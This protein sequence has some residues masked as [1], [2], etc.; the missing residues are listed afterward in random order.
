[1]T[2]WGRAGMRCMTPAHSANSA[3]KCAAPLSAPSRAASSRTSSPKTAAVKAGK[4]AFYDQI[5]LPLADAYRHCGAVMVENMLWRDTAEG[6]Q[7]FLEKR[8][9]DWN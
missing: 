5:S 3:S 8:K 7:A 6:I 9:P 2:G 1:M 4:S